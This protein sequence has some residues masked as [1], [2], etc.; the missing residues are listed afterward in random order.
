VGDLRRIECL[1]KKRYHRHIVW[2]AL[3]AEGFGA[4]LQHHTDIV[5]APLQK[6][7][8]EAFQLPSSWEVSVTSCPVRTL[9][10]N[11]LGISLLL[12]SAKL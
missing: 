7:L 4:S 1:P 10:S 9:S 5:G 6:A 12:H 2:T 8:Q 11:D 3:E